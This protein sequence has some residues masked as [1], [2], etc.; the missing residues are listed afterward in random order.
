MSGDAENAKKARQEASRLK[1]TTEM[2]LFLSAL[3]SFRQ[4][5]PALAAQTCEQVLERRPD[6]FWAQYIQALCYLKLGRF[7]EAKAGLTAC[8]GRKSDFLWPR[9]LRA[10]AHAELKEYAAAETDF[11]QALKQAKDPLDQFVLLT[12][13]GAMWARRQR[14]DAAEADLREASQLQPSAYQPYATLALIHQQRKNPDAAVTA[15][16][17]ALA[18][19]PGLP[20]LHY[21]LARTQAERGDRA[22]ACRAFEQGIACERQSLSEDGAKAYL[23]LAHLHFQDHHFTE[24]LTACEAAL[25]ADSSPPEAHLQRAEVFLAL[26]R[27]PEASEAL[28]QYLSRAKTPRAV[29]YKA[30][31]LL[32]TSLR[33]YPAALEAF[34]R[35]LL[36][37]PDVEIQSLRGWIYLKLEAPRAALGDFEAVLKRDPSH[38]DALC[39]RGHSRVILGQVPEAIRDAE[40]AL[41]AGPREEKNRPRLLL[42]TACIYARAVIQVSATRKES[43]RAAKEMALRHQERA[44]EMVRDALRQ[45]PDGER[46]AFWRQYIQ[47]ESAL[48]AIRASSGMQQLA[49][50]YGS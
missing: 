34:N 10:L 46:R 47:K 15:L 22:S 40:A 38:S 28:H 42:N 45:T 30:C 36:V 7:A 35:A 33:E 13:R 39:G 8:L 5:Q 18:R 27:D 24:A 31:G 20:G 14:W 4:E 48:N 2:D 49:R 32:H 21:A 6:H 41:R 23:E 11:E 16:N 43:Q 29:D 3:E 25:K 26:K 17:E 1:P 50:A 37:A 44:V 12:N 9:A 19:Q